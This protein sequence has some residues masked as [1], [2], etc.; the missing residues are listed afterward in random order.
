MAT[1][2]DAR[3]A[4]GAGRHRWRG[5]VKAEAAAAHRSSFIAVAIVLRGVQVWSTEFYNL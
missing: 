2:R 5:D 4:R 1:V 3:A